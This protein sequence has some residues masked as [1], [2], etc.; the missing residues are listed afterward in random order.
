MTQSEAQTRSELT[1][2]QLAQLT[3]ARNLGPFELE[4]FQYHVAKENLKMKATRLQK[5]R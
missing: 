5:S 3:G 1:D 4:I 2:K